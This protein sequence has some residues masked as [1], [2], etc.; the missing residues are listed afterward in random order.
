MSLLP[1]ASV[2]EYT[3]ADTQKEQIL[4]ENK[5]KSGIYCWINKNND[6]FYIGSAVDLKKRLQSCLFYPPTSAYLR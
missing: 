3:D 6:K 2:K 5:G 4:Q 1:I